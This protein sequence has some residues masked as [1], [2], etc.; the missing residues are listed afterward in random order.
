MRLLIKQ[1]VFSWTDTF[2]IYDEAGNPK[3]FVKGE[4]FSLGHRLHV[5]DASGQEIG[6]VRG[7]LALLPEGRL[8]V[9]TVEAS[10]VSKRVLFSHF[11]AGESAEA[12]WSPTLTLTGRFV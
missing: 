2:D 4:F 5:Y 6:L 12:Y 10:R 9:C 7:K 11:I 3:Y 8:S 1:R